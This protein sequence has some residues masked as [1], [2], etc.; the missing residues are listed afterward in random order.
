VPP[1]LL[2]RG[3]PPWS[4]LAY[5]QEWANRKGREAGQASGPRPPSGR[6]RE[7]MADGG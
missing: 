3:L 6:G 5:V 1:S 7:A 4:L 2:A